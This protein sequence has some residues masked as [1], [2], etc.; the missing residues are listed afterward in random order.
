MTNRTDDFARRSKSTEQIALER[1]ELIE[2]IAK[3]SAQIGPVA[4]DS[5]DIIRAW[6]D[7]DEP[8]R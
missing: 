3:L 7:N 6:R 5:T 4:G 1:K 2:R 8:Y